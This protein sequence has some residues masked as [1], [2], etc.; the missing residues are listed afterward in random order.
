MSYKKVAEKLIEDEKKI[1]KLRKKY[2]RY[3]YLKQIKQKGSD[4]K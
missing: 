3:W 4:G 1:K 2:G